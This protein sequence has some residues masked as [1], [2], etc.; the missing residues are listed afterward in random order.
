MLCY[1]LLGFHRLQQYIHHAFHLLHQ[2]LIK[3]WTIVPVY[4]KRAYNSPPPRTR[5][6]KFL[7][8][9]RRSKR[10]IDLLQCRHNSEKPKNVSSQWRRCFWVAGEVRPLVI[11]I[12]RPVNRCC[13]G[14]EVCV[15]FSQRF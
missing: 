1:F 13:P 14:N 9:K 6:V 15:F 4:R 11:V 2:M 12:K 8:F 7:I 5:D 3:L 10:S